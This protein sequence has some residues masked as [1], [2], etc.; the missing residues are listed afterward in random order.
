MLKKLSFSILALLVL[1]PIAL[2]AEPAIETVLCTSIENRVP[3]DS[4]VQFD[5]DVE[6]I[7]LWTRVTDYPD[8]TKLRHVWIHE[9]LER[10]D[11]ELT[12][13]GNPWRTWSYK[14]MRSEWVGNWEVKIVGVDG[15]VIKSVSFVFGEAKAKPPSKETT[16]TETALPD[17]TQKR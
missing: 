12:I 7:Y 3:L 16:K 8:Q 4:L 6:R 10:S 1:I 14:T 9:G 11:V 17:S 13:K 15:E 5:N 2:K